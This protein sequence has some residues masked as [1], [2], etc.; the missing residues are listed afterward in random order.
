MKS[1]NKQSDTIT[2]VDIPRSS[3]PGGFALVA[4]ISVMVLLVMVALAMISLSSIE[5][6]SSRRNEAMAQAK[7]NAR[8]ALIL[9]IGDL[10]MTMGPDQR[11][12]ASA[13]I[14]DARPE[15]I[16]ID[17]VNQAHLTG[18][19]GSWKWQPGE[20]SPDYRKIK[21]DRFLRWLTSDPQPEALNDLAYPMASPIDP[22]ILVGAQSVADPKDQV[23]ASRIQLGKNKG[24]L[25]G[26]VAWSVFDEG[27]K[28]R[29]SLSD[30]PT[31][32]LAAEIER[33]A[34]PPLPGFEGH[35]DV[36]IC[37]VWGETGSGIVDVSKCI[38]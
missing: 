20:K 32:S 17:E 19:W 7:A 6:R 35:R 18:V 13:G 33:L 16:D 28:A 31:N 5:L 23:M 10:Q 21:E 15:S 24:G 2:A 29:I 25:K 9:A 1:K 30:A 12:S 38:A 14:L 11:I 4:T 36:S 26:A 8:M 3:L 34:A 27:Q 22:V 37:C